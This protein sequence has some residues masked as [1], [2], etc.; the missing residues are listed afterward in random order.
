[1]VL[2]LVVALTFSVLSVQTATVEKRDQ[3]CI[4]IKGTPPKPIDPKGVDI[5]NFN[6]I[7]PSPTFWYMYSGY[8]SS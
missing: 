6:D 5:P 7:N 4:R 2:F 3:T 1:M 8:F